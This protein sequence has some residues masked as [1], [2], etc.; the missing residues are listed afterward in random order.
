MTVRP[1]LQPS[2]TSTGRCRANR[3]RPNRPPLVAGAELAPAPSGIEEMTMP[4]LPERTATVAPHPHRKC[5]SAAILY[6]CSGHKR[7]DNRM[8]GRAQLQA[9]L[10]AASGALEP[11]L[12]RSRSRRLARSQRPISRCGGAR[13]TILCSTS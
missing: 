3:L 11:A 5:L 13:S 7:Y 9:P 12:M 6:G 1:E 4:R 10:L 2:I 8:P